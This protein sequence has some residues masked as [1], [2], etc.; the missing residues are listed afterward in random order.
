MMIFIASPLFVRPLKANAALPSFVNEPQPIFEDMWSEPINNENYVYSY[1]KLL[2]FITN[3]YTIKNTANYFSMTYKQKTTSS[4]DYQNMGF[5][6]D[7]ADVTIDGNHIIIE[8]MVNGTIHSWCTYD[9]TDIYHYGLGKIDFDFDTKTFKF[10]DKQGGTNYLR[11]LYQPSWPVTDIWNVYTN[12]DG[13]S[14]P[15]PSLDLEVTFSPSMS[16]SV[17]RQGTANGSSVTYNYLDLN[18]Q[19]HGDNAQWLFAIV[20]HGQSLTFPESILNTPQGFNGSPTFVYIADEW[21][22]WTNGLTGMTGNYGGIDMEMLYSP[23]AWH[24][25]ITQSDRTY[26]INWD[27]MKLSKNVSYDC[28]VYGMINEEP[29]NAS[30]SGSG[31]GCWTVKSALSDIQEVYRS[32]FTMSNPPTF[33]PNSVDEGNSSHPWDPD[34]DNSG[35]F[36]SGNVYKDSN[37]NFVI[38]GGSNNSNGSGGS[39]Y[40]NSSSV[41]NINNIFRNFFRFI[42]GVL[43][44]FPSVYQNIIALGLSALIVVGVVKVAIK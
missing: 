1:N 30:S 20:P 6:Y 44:C 3:Q 24:T 21:I 41:N 23:C 8:N 25:L 36:N 4:Y 7:S 22:D 43:M 32:T 12:I 33:N 11:Y 29:V 27:M 19:N 15:S 35:I 28:V 39:F 42:S 37:G 13:L 26:H 9:N 38:K 18:I 2:T 17:T 16:G 5:Y 14:V 34:I 31:L 40:V 10:W